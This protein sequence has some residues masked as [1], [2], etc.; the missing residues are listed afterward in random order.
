MMIGFVI[1]LPL[2]DVAPSSASADANTSSF[3][4]RGVNL[5][6]ALASEAKVALA[7]HRVQRNWQTSPF[8]YSTA[9]QSRI[10]QLLTAA[11]IY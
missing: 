1:L 3:A 7:A 9:T 8:R 11:L 4:P 5:G 2:Y 10:R 6:T